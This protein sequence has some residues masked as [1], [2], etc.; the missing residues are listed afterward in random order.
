M[1]SLKEMGKKEISNEK[2]QYKKIADGIQKVIEDAGLKN[3]EGGYELAKSWLIN[4]E[5]MDKKYLIKYLVEN[6]IP[7]I[8]NGVTMFCTF[9]LGVLTSLWV[10]EEA[11]NI[12]TFPWKPFV[13][14]FLVFFSLQ[15]F[16]NLYAKSII[17]GYNLRILREMT[18]AQYK[19]L[20]EENNEKNYKK[21]ES[22][23]CLIFE[24]I[25]RG[26]C[27]EKRLDVAMR[28]ETYHN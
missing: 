27:V 6:L 28:K 26:I 16:L 19:S 18:Y 4:N 12:L 10:N 9:L 5:L 20:I 15:F 23:K 24:K 1:N 22:I 13:G 21:R 11:A 8:S 3:D 25:N 2:K 14:V 7:E 17:E